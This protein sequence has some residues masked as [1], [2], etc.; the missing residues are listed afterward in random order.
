VTRA[1]E[2]ADLLAC[3]ELQASHSGEPVVDVEERLQ[4]ELARPDRRLLVA[5][6]DD[7]VAGYG[8]VSEHRPARRDP[9]DA[10][11]GY[12]L[13]GVVVDPRYRRRGLGLAL[14][15]A[16]MALVFT[17][18]DEVWYFANARNAASIAMHA[19]LGFA[20]VTRN[21]QF[22]GVAFAGGQGVLFR[23]SR[24]AVSDRP[25]VSAPGWR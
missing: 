17:M 11:P 16:R 7:A 18:A 9:T 19:Q 2:P 3:S 5:I 15:R 13:G 14:T 10:P 21:F 24:P 8:R 12:Y 22:P 25:E 20:E 6:V 4:T 1:A 23:A